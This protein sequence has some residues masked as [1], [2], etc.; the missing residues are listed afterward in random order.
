MDIK[1][2]WR[3]K[4]ESS[5]VP[6]DSYLSELITVAGTTIFLGVTRSVLGLTLKV[7]IWYWPLNGILYL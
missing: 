1:R 7:G 3:S 2:V 5:K 6:L 4:R